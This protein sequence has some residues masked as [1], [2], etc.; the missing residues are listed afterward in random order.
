L[1]VTATPIVNSLRDLGHQLLLAVRDDALVFDGIGSL[2]AMLFAGCAAQALGQLVLEN[3][4][5][6]E[7][8]PTRR[9]RQSLPLEQETTG[10]AYQLELLDRLR[11]SRS[12][13]IA[14]LI[15]TV[16]L[17]ALA[18]SPAAFAGALRRYRRLLLSARDALD[19]GQPLSRIDLKRLT[20]DLSDQLVWWELLAGTSAEGDLDLDDLPLLDRHIEA[21]DIATR[22]PDG[23]LERLQAILEQPTP[24]IVFT[25]FRDT[26]RYLRQRLESQPV[27]WCTG[28]QAGVG[29]TR[30]PR[31]TVLGWFRGPPTSSLVPRHVIVT[32]VAA[33]GLDLQRAARVVHYDL[34]WTPMRLEQREGRSVRYGSQHAYVEVIRFALPRELE[35]KLQ[36]ERVL[37]RK[38]RL[39]AAAG[40]GPNGGRVW[41]WRAE[42]AERYRTFT[43]QAGVAAV[44][45]SEPG[46]LAGFALGR[47]GCRDPIASSIFWLDA[48]GAWTEAPGEISRRLAAA[49]E[50]DRIVPVEPAILREWVALLTPYLRERLTLARSRRWI[51][52]DPTSAGLRVMSRLQSLIREAARQRRAARLA[53]LDRALAFVAG[54]HTAGEMIVIENL[55]QATDRELERLLSKLPVR[56]FRWEELAIR[57][58]G[59][60][61]FG[62]AQNSTSPLAFPGAEA[63]DSA[64]RSR[65]NPD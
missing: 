39:P 38:G 21:A 45:S 15:R 2:R 29:H 48:N 50:Q 28:N 64:I 49:A 58:T 59:L 40:I 19:A 55:V 31:S 41:R 27:A 20:Q 3:E 46:L 24:T 30:V 47:S 25:S 5:V 37:A 34:P 1:L 60:V 62:P 56:R 16:L 26:V 51:T 61:V 54:G 18:S 42:L 43:A 11:L 32:D 6:T 33:E 36:L 4:T 13:A 10:I 44:E 65:R 63:P 57:L 7:R 14:A 22:E 9:L 17:R 12:G 53:Q 35:R 52:P 8:R 23:K